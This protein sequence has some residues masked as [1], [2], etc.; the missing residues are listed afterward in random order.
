MNI[1]MKEHQDKKAQ[2]EYYNDYYEDEEQ[3]EHIR[4]LIVYFKDY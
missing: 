1:I 4:S 3:I 2:D